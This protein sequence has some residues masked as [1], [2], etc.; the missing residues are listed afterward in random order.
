MLRHSSDGEPGYSRKRIGQHWA[1]FDGDKRV[2]DRE[3]IDRLNSIALPPAYKD[4]WF[5]KDPNGHLQMP[6]SRTMR[7]PPG[8]R[9]WYYAN[10]PSAAVPEGLG[11]EA[12]IRAIWADESG[13]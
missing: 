12:A 3:T 13:R 11:D 9:R 5:C 2:T 7:S 1:Y 6:G 10:R 8:G 4:A